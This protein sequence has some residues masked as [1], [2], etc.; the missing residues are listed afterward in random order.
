MAK[1]SA[2]LTSGGD[3]PGMN[4]AIRSFIRIANSRGIEVFGISGGYEGLLNE[5]MKQLTSRDV[6][7]VINHGGTFLK[8][9]RSERFRQ[10]QGLRTGSGKF[11][12]G[13]VLSLYV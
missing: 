5:Q 8:T 2:I 12:G 7:M 9:S 4:A 6:G 13:V 10:K 11:S 1:K 3:S